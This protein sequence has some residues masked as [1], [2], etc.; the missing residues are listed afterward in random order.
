[1]NLSRLLPIFLSFFF[2]CGSA[3]AAP[4]GQA[5]R[6]IG[7]EITLWIRGSQAAKGTYNRMDQQEKSSGY[8]KV[9]V[10][11]MIAC[12]GVAFL[13]TLTKPSR[14]A[15][16]RRVPAAPPQSAQ[17]P[18]FPV[19]VAPSVSPPPQANQPPS[20]FIGKDGKQAGP[21]TTDQVGS[22]LQG[23]LLLPSDLVWHEGRPDWI[24][25]WQ[26]FGM[27]SPT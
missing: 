1:M 7:E 4:S 17:P 26:F 2:L 23:G 5:L 25:L 3:Q 27:A 15:A 21:F 16:A 12:L 11:V 8:G 14:K 9:L 19:A 20:L 13:K 18:P 24:P 6:A 10:V 22:M